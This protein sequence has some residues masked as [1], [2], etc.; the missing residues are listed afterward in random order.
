MPSDLRKR[1][2]DLYVSAFKGDTLDPLEQEAYWLWCEYKYWPL[3][4]NIARDAAILELGCGPGFMLEYLRT[5]GFTDLRGIDI[6]AEQ[7]ELAR[8]ANR[9]AEVADVFQY[10]EGCNRQFGA[11]LAIDFLEHF[12]KEELDRLIRLIRQS[13]CTGGWFILQTPNGAG[14]FSKQIVYDDLTHSTILSVGSLRQILEL[15]GFGDVV[16]RETGPTPKNIAGVLRL[17][18]WRTIR[19]VASAIKKIES[20]KRQEIWTENVICS[21]R[22]GTIPQ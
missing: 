7:I 18:A 21:C 17:T 20:G 2:Y 11:I 8:A 3:L 4:H 12:T 5:H 16:F 19:F 10:L 9:P 22:A 1:L 13:L 14:L 6:S 15:N